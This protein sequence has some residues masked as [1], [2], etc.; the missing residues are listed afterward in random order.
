MAFKDK[1]NSLL[2]EKNTNVQRV[3]KD[4]KIPRTTMYD[5]SHGRTA[6]TLKHVKTLS[7]YFDVPMERFVD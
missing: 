5:W 7:D 2:E 4:T 1:F 3:S 6:P